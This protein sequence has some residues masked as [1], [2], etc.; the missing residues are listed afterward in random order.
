MQYDNAV[1]PVSGVYVFIGRSNP[2]SVLRDVVPFTGRPTVTSVGVL[3]P[4]TKTKDDHR[5][6]IYST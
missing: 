1:V 4:S 6:I 3:A 2:L 5:I